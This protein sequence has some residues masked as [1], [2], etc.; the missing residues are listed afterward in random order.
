MTRNL[1][2]TS[3]RPLAAPLAMSTA[4]TPAEAA[5]TILPERLRNDRHNES[6]EIDRPGDGY[7]AN[8][9]R[10]RV[11]VEDL[12]HEGAIRFFKQASPGSLLSDA[13]VIVLQ[14][15]YTRAMPKPP[16]RSVTLILESFDGVAFTKG[17]DLDNDHKEIHLSLNYIA[18]IKET[19]ATRLRDE[20]RGVIVHEMVHVWQ[21]NGK[22]TCP[23]GLIEGIA[24][25]V[26]L[27]AN[28]AP[29]HWS[30]TTGGDW[31][32][33]YD[34]TAFFLD[35]LEKEYGT[36]TV[37]KMNDTL[38]HQKY[39]QDRFWAGLFNKSVR[40]LWNQYQSSLDDDSS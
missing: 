35:W 18:S 4:T 39:D 24:D 40:Q 2:G 5:P 25:W 8:P 28:L 31:D 27:R 33:G 16:I 1:P 36:G 38:R 9:P 11:R 15:I 13:I 14:H 37:L 6:D 19:T 32:A 22:G 3:R 23:G 7:L 26:R 30:R 17:S 34:K 20:I 21:H 10:L 29:P 12:T